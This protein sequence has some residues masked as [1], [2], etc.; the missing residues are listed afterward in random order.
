MEPTLLNVAAIGMLYAVVLATAVLAVFARRV[1]SRFEIATAAAGG[2]GAAVEA[3]GWPV[4]RPVHASSRGWMTRG[5]IA[6]LA[7]AP[8]LFLVL[9]KVETT[10]LEALAGLVG[11]WTFCPHWPISGKVCP[12]LSQGTPERRAQVIALGV[13]ATAAVLADRP[14]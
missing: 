5:R 11:D 13:V 7:A 10:V 4:T 2:S 6:A 3:R 12:A 1:N 14:R 9:V 8:L